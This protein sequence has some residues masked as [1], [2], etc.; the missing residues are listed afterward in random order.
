M[1]FWPGAAEVVDE[2]DFAEDSLETPSCRGSE[3]SCAE[4]RRVEP[5]ELREAFE[6]IEEAEVVC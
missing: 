5:A 3:V 6:A 4:L 1:S 2:E